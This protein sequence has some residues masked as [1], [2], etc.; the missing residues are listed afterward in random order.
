M[1]GTQSEKVQDE[2]RA[3]GHVVTVARESVGGVALIGIDPTTGQ[4]TAVGSATG[5][6][7]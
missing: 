6:M 1:P 4:A 3:R 2:L 7:E 5:K